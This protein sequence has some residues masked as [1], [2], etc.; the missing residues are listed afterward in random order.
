AATGVTA[1]FRSV[2]GLYISNKGRITIND[3]HPEF[4]EFR[5]VSETGGGTVTVGSVTARTNIF[6]WT[7]K[8]P[9]P[10]DLPP[11]KYRLEAIGPAGAT[12]KRW[13]VEGW[14]VSGMGYFAGFAGHQD[15]DYCALDLRRGESVRVS[16]ANWEQREP[17]D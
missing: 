4:H 5:V 1:A 17:H 8:P 15:G 11:G 13:R 3:F 10:L 12:V 2:L 14:H 6:R 16:I 9:E 7:V